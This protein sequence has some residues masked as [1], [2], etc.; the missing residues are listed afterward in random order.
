MVEKD[1]LTVAIS[2]I[3][4]EPIRTLD[5]LGEYAF[6]QY[7]EL[8]GLFISHLVKF[9]PWETL[10]REQQAVW[11]NLG[12]RVYAQAIADEVKDKIVAEEKSSDVQ[13]DPDRTQPIGH[14]E[15]RKLL[16]EAAGV[17]DYDAR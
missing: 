17:K 7:V 1:D 3:S 15:L 12:W 11:I 2:N 5:D 10:P 6:N 16:D 8:Q 4:S 13:R 9:H 14:E